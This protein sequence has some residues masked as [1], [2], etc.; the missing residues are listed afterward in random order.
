M[1]YVI[2]MFV[3]AIIGY[4]TNWLAIKMLFKPHTERK[5]FGIK[6]PFTPGLIPKERYR[7]SKSIGEAVGHHLLTPMK[8]KEVLSS[9][10]TQRNLNEWIN[11]NLNRLKKDNRSV[12]D[13]I[14]SEDEDNYNS[15]I[16]GIK[17]KI[18]GYIVSRFKDEKFK[19]FF[20]SFIEHNIYERYK[21]LA[22]DNLNLEGKKLLTEIFDSQEMKYL[23]MGEL[24]R[25]LERF[26]DDHRPLKE[27][28]S[29]DTMDNIYRSVE[30]NKSNILDGLRKNFYSSELSSRLKDSIE[31]LVSKN[32]N[33][34]LMMFLDPS[35]IA[36]KIFVIIQRYIDS[37][38]AEEFIIFTIG[39]IIDRILDKEISTI[40]SELEVLVDEENIGDMII[41]YLSKDMDHGKIME[42]LVEG[43][44]HR[45]RDIKDR[46]LSYI[47]YGFE[48]IINSHEFKDKVFSIIDIH[49]DN[50]LNM[51]MDIV[52]RNI[53]SSYVEQTMNSIRSIFN[54]FF[55]D[56]LIDII[57]LF[58]ISKIVEEEIN[59][60]E[61]EYTEK[62][63]LDIAEKEL[64][65]ITNLGALLG[66]IMGLLSPLLQMIS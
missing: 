52:L 63:I 21:V 61:V 54:I 37:P 13:I 2:P 46:F 38:A 39:N 22:L 26:K 29:Q 36:D 48:D 15:F 14:S 18:S 43:I 55:Q 65:A 40:V 24:N 34:T 59:G 64:K 30:K 47:S 31:N 9:E 23:I 44:R 7:I 10:E 58:D 6:I 8:I 3:G 66:G 49:I 16:F 17:D 41:K 45:D 33:R 50:T 42:F 51:P 53:E 11:L 4:F 28:I 12:M 1:K 25:G 27:V 60:F 56:M 62:L 20:L 5:I 19:V 57:D 35:T 32:M